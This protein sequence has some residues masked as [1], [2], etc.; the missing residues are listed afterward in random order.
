MEN[1]DYEED[2]NEAQ[3]LIDT[4]KDPEVQKEVRSVQNIDPLVSLKANLFSFFENRLK[5]IEKEDE[6]EKQI[7]DALLMKIEHDELSTAQLMQLYNSV[8]S[9]GSKALEVLLDV[10]KPSQAGNVSPLVEEKKV[11]DSSGVQTDGSAGGF[12]ELKPEERDAV[13]KLAKMVS[14]ISSQQQSQE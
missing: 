10:F 12:Q 8:K 13:H 9:Q 5:A 2:K 11:E 14:E 3:E 1:H 4:L 7:K 6:F